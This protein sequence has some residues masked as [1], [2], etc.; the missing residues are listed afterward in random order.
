MTGNWTTKAAQL[1]QRL[2][3][4]GSRYVQ[5][6]AWLITDSI[7]VEPR[8]WL[9]IAGATLLN[10]ASN[11]GVAGAI[12]FYVD[13]LQQ[14]LHIDVMGTTIIARESLPLLVAFIVV[15]L[16]AMLS[17]AASEYIAKVAAL[18]LHRR[19]QAHSVRR[20]LRLLQYLPDPRCPQVA[21]QIH[22]IGTR[23]LV[24]TYPHS[25]GW[26][27]R[28]IGNAFPNL[29][30]FVVGYAALIWLDPAATAVVSALGL[31]VIAAQYPVHLLAARSSNILEETSPYV[32]QKLSTLIGFASGFRGAGQAQRLEARL[33]D[34]EQD[35]R[36]RRNADADENRFRAM[37]LS[38]LSM[39]TGGGV[40]LAAMLL[41]I[42]SGLLS[43]AANWAILIVY[44]T[45][46]RRLLNSLTTVFRT[47]AVFS[48]FSPQVSS[49]RS[50]VQGAS[51]AAAPL[52]AMRAVPK[53]VSLCALDRDGK[54]SE[55]ELERGVPLAL[56]SA[57][58]LN[59]ELALTLQRALFE[60]QSSS[61]KPML[62]IRAVT[63]DD[64]RDAASALQTLQALEAEGPSLMLVD[65]TAHAQLVAAQLK[66]CPGG[67][68]ADFEIIF[69][70]TVQQTRFGELF[71]LIKD[72]A[73]RLH[74]WPL[75]TDIVDADHLGAI[76]ALVASGAGVK[77][78]NT[79]LE[80]DAG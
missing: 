49:Y 9:R 38:A 36:V 69:Y 57:G 15:M 2:P 22:E 18:R 50:F 20:T 77:V 12:Y 8:L 47:V 7:R 66:S 14:D 79:V 21:A 80:E 1:T 56:F 13:L 4:Q 10:L 16:V 28:F 24:T 68:L 34:F 27:L 59:R 54:M 65:H 3:A 35:R 32:S 58:A 40:I 6:L 42:G 17:F 26:S 43:N 64:V 31:G 72:R 73:D 19:Y 39:Q 5:S 33:S 71:A 78:S 25:C 23:K 11:A 55:M 75:P 37:D 51:V 61:H 52:V 74:C 46:L 44:A 48:R 70:P 29:V 62:P 53:L 30:L 45:V 41:T 60:A 67:I 76:G 63:A